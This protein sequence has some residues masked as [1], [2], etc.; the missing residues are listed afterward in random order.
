[1][2]F[3]RK[4]TLKDLKVFFVYTILLFIS[5]ISVLTFRFV[6]QSYDLYILFYRFFIVGEFA[7]ISHFF[8]FNIMQIRLKKLIKFLIVPFSI[9]SIYD[10][11]TSFGKPF[12]F[13]PLVLECLLFPLIIILFFYERMKYITKAPIYQSA[14][15][16]IAV[17]FLVFS[18]GNFF[19]F[20]SSKLLLQDRQNMALYNHIYD[21]FTVLKNIFL[22][23]AIK[24]SRNSKIN[25]NEFE[26]IINLPFENFTSLKNKANL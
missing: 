23:I 12:T 25:N 15:F 2:Y 4:N 18:T 3:L 8:A 1:M 20:L 21:F 7:L 14:T 26:A 19:L 24:S 13:Y 10:Y 22:C 17:G 11:I 9:F 5:I 16:W 6:F